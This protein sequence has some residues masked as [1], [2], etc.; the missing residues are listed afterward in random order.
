MPGEDVAGEVVTV[1]KRVLAEAEAGELVAVAI[2]RQYR[3]DEE[4]GECGHSWGFKGGVE[5]STLLGGIACLQVD[6]AHLVY[7][8]TSISRD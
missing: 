4:K 2:V 5:L 3:R 1:L 8:G 6:F 7:R